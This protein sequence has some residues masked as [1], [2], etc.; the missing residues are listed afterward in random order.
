MNAL[1]RALRAA[2]LFLAAAAAV[3]FAFDGGITHLFFLLAFPATVGLLL[4]GIRYRWRRDRR[5]P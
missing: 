1:F 5:R 4:L 3:V 2:A